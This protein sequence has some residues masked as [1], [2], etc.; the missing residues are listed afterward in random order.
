MSTQNGLVN[1]SNMCYRNS[2]VQ[3]LIAL[4]AIQE[5][6][7][8]TDMAN[9]DGLCRMLRTVLILFQ[10][11]NQAVDIETDI[12]FGGIPA[13]I[14]RI[15]SDF[16]QMDVNEYFVN[17]LE[18]PHGK[19]IRDM[20]VM[21]L[22]EV[23]VFGSENGPHKTR[24]SITEMVYM[25]VLANDNITENHFLKHQVS[26][27]ECNTQKTDYAFPMNN[28][29]LLCVSIGTPKAAMRITEKILVEHV[30]IPAQAALRGVV[31][32]RLFGTIFR[33]SADHVRGGHYVACVLN[34]VHGWMCHVS[35][36]APH[37]PCVV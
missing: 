29:L 32:Y 1:G 35:G 11:Q 34:D 13:D 27:L 3:C 37:P 31:E 9:D 23:D 25:R 24:R 33:N 22:F 20:F 12:H 15:G 18:H 5:H 14:L 21:G 30:R 17:I 26:M 6:L 2:V 8:N 10:R 28:P 36:R 4:P 7:E 16:D 19:P